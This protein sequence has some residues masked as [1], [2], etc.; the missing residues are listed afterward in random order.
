MD[1]NTAQEYAALMRQAQ[2]IAPPG[3]ADIEQEAT[4]EF[5]AWVL[6]GGMRGSLARE[7]DDD[8]CMVW[9]LEIRTDRGKLE[10]TVNSPDEWRTVVADLGLAD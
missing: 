7:L 1:A 4:E 2:A 6:Q 10:Q 8:G 5:M 9:R 3:D